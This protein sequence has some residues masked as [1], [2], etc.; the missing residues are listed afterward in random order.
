MD[1]VWQV[2]LDLTADSVPVNGEAGSAD[3]RSRKNHPGE[4]DP[5][6]TPSV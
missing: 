6:A 2:L 1:G 5:D 3:S 4:Q